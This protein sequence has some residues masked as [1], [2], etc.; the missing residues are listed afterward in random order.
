MNQASSA[1][2][3]RLNGDTGSN[4][5]NTILWG[6]GS[7]V[8]SY[9][10][11]NSNNIR[12]YGFN[13]GPTG[14]GNN[15]NVIV[16]IQNYSNATTYK[17]VLLRS[18][19]TQVE[20]AAG[21]G[22]WRNTAAI[23]SAT[24]TSYNGTDTFTT[25]TTFTFYGIAAA[26]VGAKAT[27]GTIYQDA[28]YFYHVFSG[29]GTFTPSQALTADILTIAGGGGGGGG[30]YG[31]TGGGGGAGGLVAFMSQSLANGT[32]YTCTIGAG[33]TA[34][35]SSSSPSTS[36][37]NSQFGALTAAIGGGRGGEANFGY[38]DGTGG[39]GGSGGGAGGNGSNGAGK[40]G[41]TATSGQGYNGGSAYGSGSGGGG[42]G[43][44]AIGIDG[45]N[46]DP[47]NG[48]NGGIGS[49]AYSTWLS[50]T[51]FG[52][53]VSGTYYIASGGGGGAASTGTS[54]V[55]GYGGGG[56]G[57]DTATAGVANTG[58][59]GGGGTN[60]ANKLNG[61]NGGSGVV[62]IRYPKA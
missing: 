43:A 38:P 32:G 50:A 19:L 26:S 44:G 21:V 4:Y 56:N 41:G 23:T 42:G 6:N 61:G 24:V 17:S 35:R 59:G 52:Q 49:S 55:G 1:A 60:N 28:S 47:A 10:E 15:D 40:P 3:L 13:S 14:S 27:G 33:G 58:G 54:G 29:S 37:S 18:N 30:W 2:K 16:S 51:G 34:T 46:S 11:N 36:G 53:N 39:N 31:P 5:S 20:L 57:G 9:R 25:G 22:L 48:G 62:I 8:T 7:T 12:I 45:I